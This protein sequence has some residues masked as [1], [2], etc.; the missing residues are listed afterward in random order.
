MKISQQTQ[1]VDEEETGTCSNP[2]VDS[3]NESK[4]KPYNSIQNRNLRDLETQTDFQFTPELSSQKAEIE[5][6]NL[7]ELHHAES[8][9]M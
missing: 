4:V 8:D 1:T 6:Q 9:R 2:F 3:E 5:I 7:I